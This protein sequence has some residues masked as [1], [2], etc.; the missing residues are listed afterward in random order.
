MAVDESSGDFL[1]GVGTD[2]ALWAEAF[3]ETLQ[4]Y[5]EGV[6]DVGF[7]CG[8]FSNA[9]EAGRTAG[10]TH[11]ARTGAYRRALEGAGVL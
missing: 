11:E 9:I 10:K 2:A 1:R 3:Y 6:S 5:P 4:N 7:L 8:W